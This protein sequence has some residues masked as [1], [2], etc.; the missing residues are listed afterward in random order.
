MI[1]TL[2]HRGAIHISSHAL[3]A[4]KQVNWVPIHSRRSLQVFPRRPLPCSRVSSPGKESKKTF[5]NIL[6]G[7]P[8]QVP[9]FQETRA[10][11]SLRP[12]TTMLCNQKPPK[13]H[14]SISEIVQ[15]RS[16]ISSKYFGSFSG[17]YRSILFKS[18][19]FSFFF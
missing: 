15:T 10:S 1:S 13:S 11:T 2:C 5:Q 18:C 4:G 9:L 12:S 14:R 6:W 8:V 17:F 19:S 7:C 3:M 16:T